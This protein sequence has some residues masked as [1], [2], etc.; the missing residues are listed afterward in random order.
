MPWPKIAPL[1][2]ALSA[3]LA[4]AQAGDAP[5]PNSTIPVTSM[6][7]GGPAL[8][9]ISHGTPP[10]AL[11]GI[12][13]I[14]R[15]G[16]PIR[17]T[18]LLYR[19]GLYLGSSDG[20]FYAVDAR[21]GHPLWTLRASGPV[22]SSPAASGDLVYFVAR[23]N[24]LYAVTADR[25]AIRWQQDLGA[26][27]GS[28]NYWDF[29]ASSPALVND[30][31]FVGSGDGRLY[32][33]E[34][35]SGRRLW[36]FDAGAR[37]RSTPAVVDNTVVFGAL[38]GRIYA[39]DAATGKQKWTYATRGASHK[40][41][42]K[43]NDTTSVVASPT[44][45]NGIVTTGGRDGYLY[46]LDLQTGKL[47][48]DLTHDGASW[49]LSTASQQGTLFVGS[50]SAFIL[51]AVDLATGKEQWRFKTRSAVFSSPTI[52]GDVVVF[53][54]LSGLVHALTTT[55]GK[56]LW[57]FPLP[58]RPLASP[59]LG[60]HVLYLACDDGKLLALDTAA[61][62]PPHATS[63]RR[64]VYWQGPQSAQSFSWFPK[65]I[66]ES[67]RD[68]FVRSGFERID[69]AQLQQAIDDQIA[70]RSSSL[71]VFADDRIPG[72][73]YD[74]ATQPAPIRRF[75]DSGGG[76]IFLGMPPVDFAVDPKSGETV[77]ID[78]QGLKNI[79]SIE[80]LPLEDERGYHTAA[81]TADGK[82]WGLE[83]P[84]VSN[85]GVS[86]RNVTTT[87]ARNEFGS[88]VAWYKVIGK[89]FLLQLS[90]P[91]NRLPDLTES[92]WTIEHTDV[93]P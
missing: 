42:D 18:P 9:G 26:D 48:W 91:N 87:L 80:P 33:I 1:A 10:R 8:T 17:S 24:T 72:P 7:K 22:A 4:L 19:S 50:G 16:G 73:L 92:L 28:S 46:A 14:V 84:F 11:E 60:D 67:I 43:S 65:G 51:Q 40:F 70:G 30:R 89:G 13:F 66:D 71:I 3:S 63:R 55:T 62:A 41:A 68:F 77:G 29:F 81:P 27:K 82:R 75:V 76:V 54:D 2:L 69:R 86:S 39:V 23:P 90:L 61:T 47:R 25:G 38:N 45:A 79:F 12:R 44:V 37:I 49:I 34:A 35:A 58:D 21:D 78:D 31:L 85:G 52:A 53:S 6:F 88:A 5:S 32:C 74:T 20:L 59:V 83:T 56:E 15:T 93:E 36:S 64:L 57:N